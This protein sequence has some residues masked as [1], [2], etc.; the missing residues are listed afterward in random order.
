[1]YHEAMFAMLL[2]VALPT[3][4]PL[5]ESSICEIAAR[6]ELLLAQRGKRLSV[7]GRY[8]L[9]MHYDFVHPDGCEDEALSV[10]FTEGAYGQIH[11]FMLS[12]Y[13]GPNVGGGWVWGTFT[14]VVTV[15]PDRP[16]YLL[17]DTVAIDPVHR[18][19]FGN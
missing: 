8:D 18:M 5:R 2:L 1:M 6:P 4:P 11:A 12:I 3:S 19:T 15:G 14:G 10:A 7:T 9:A 17:V 13:P 16:P